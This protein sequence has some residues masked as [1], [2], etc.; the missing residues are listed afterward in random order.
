MLGLV[1]SAAVSLGLLVSM[2]APT[3][4]QAVQYGMIVLLAS[5]FLGG[6]FLDIERLSYPVKAISMLLPLTYGIRGV[7]DVMLRG[8]EPDWTDLAGLVA[9][10]LVYSAL[11]TMRFRRT[12][13]V[14]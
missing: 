4:A 10:T 1:L 3:D 12:M 14:V 5:L 11:A 6:F 8:I 2:I 9:L 7:Q 13:R